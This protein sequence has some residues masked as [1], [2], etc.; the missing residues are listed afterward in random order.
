MG[1]TE[2][3]L[4]NPENLFGPFQIFGGIDAEPR[5]G[6]LD[7]ADGQAVVDGAQLFEFFDIFD[8]GVVKG[9][10]VV[11]ALFGEAVDADMAEIGCRAAAVVGDGCAGEVDGVVV[12]VDDDFDEV[13]ILRRFTVD[14][15]VAA[16][17]NELLFM[18]REASDALEYARDNFGLDERF[19]GLDIDH[20]F[21][22]TDLEQLGAFVDAVSAAFVRRRRQCRRN[23]VVGTGFDDA[24]VIGG[25][26]DF[27]D[28]LYPLR[29]T[30]DHGNTA[31]IGEDFFGET[32]GG[33]PGGDDYHGRYL[34]RV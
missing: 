13:W 30:D 4:F 26:H 8:G 24:L 12:R 32:G 5:R 10:E 7:H 23:T 28:L 29:G 21:V 16:D 31:D 20:R 27:V 2:H 33:E 18:L 9:A 22:V 17:H 19:V 15:V 6:D 1:D 34:N 14:G 3:V 25:D 11:E